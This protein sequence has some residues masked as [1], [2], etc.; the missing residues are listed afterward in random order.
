[1]R[2]TT[3]ILT[4]LAVAGLAVAG[5]SAFTGTGLG[6][7]GQASAGQFVGGSISQGVTGAVLD[8]I[9][10]GYVDEGTK[11][12]VDTITLTFT[13]AA[14]GLNVA[15]STTGGNDGTFSCTDVASLGSVCTYAAGDDEALG[16]T[17]ITDL[18]VT[19]SP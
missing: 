11:T 6:T 5:G 14:N 15:A 1:M 9:V 16:S 10:Y 12:A 7:T 8:S 18:S 3:K 4:G 13:T 19:V 2:N 17:G